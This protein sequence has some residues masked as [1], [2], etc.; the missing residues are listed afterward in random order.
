MAV[1]VEGDFYETNAN[2]FRLLSHLHEEELQ[3]QEYL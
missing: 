1:E 2:R 3:E